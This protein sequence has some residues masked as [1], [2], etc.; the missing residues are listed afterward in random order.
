M[1]N[2]IINTIL[3]QFNQKEKLFKCKQ[4]KRM[5]YKIKMILKD[6]L[7]EQMLVGK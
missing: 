7:L 5:F 2:N 6:K 4:E 3:D 1:N